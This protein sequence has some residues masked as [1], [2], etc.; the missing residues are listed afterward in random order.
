MAHFIL[1]T[2]VN[3]TMPIA[4]YRRGTRSALSL[5][6]GTL[7]LVFEAGSAYAQAAPPPA[8]PTLSE[9]AG[10]GAAAQTDAA[11]DIQP[12]TVRPDGW[13]PGI[14][15]GATLNLN[16][17]RSVVGVQD[18]TAFTAGYLLDAEL[19]FNK[20]QH[21][22]R[23]TLLA[24]AGAARAPALPE[25][26]KTNDVLA[27]ESIYLFHATEVFGPFARFALNTTM[28]PSLDVRSTPAN[29]AVAELDGTTTSFTGRRLDLT[30][31]FAPLILKQ[32]VGAFVQPLH[33]DWMNLEARAGIGA[34]EGFAKDNLALADDAATLDVVEVK[35]LDDFFMV[36]AEAVVNATGFLDKAKRVS[37]VLGAGVLIPFVTN[38]LPE[39]DDRSLP[40]LTAVE[41]LA[42]LNVKLF[43]WASFNYRF[44]VVRQPLLVDEW[45]ISNTGLLTFAARFGSK[46]P[47]PEPTC[48]CPPPPPPAVEPQPSTTS[49]PTSPP[50]PPAAPP[51]APP[52]QPEPTPSEVV[53]PTP[54]PATP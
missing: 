47:T 30:D 43:D 34:Q 40:E 10:A 36:G 2:E 28:F 33:E 17:A 32:S 44:T 37:Y 50:P 25:F 52:P 31:P 5:L 12:A 26:V 48:D 49:A 14:A 3:S 45:Q 39:G 16:D 19:S 23:N 7:A 51:P 46:A 22:W 11:G 8:P 27:L 18:G 13:T 24:S 9:D 53:A 29:Y 1:L 38:D 21:E 54:A 42:G 4:S 41:G 20:V 6:T 15:L 35:A